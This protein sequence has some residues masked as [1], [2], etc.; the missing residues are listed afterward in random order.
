MEG[1]IDCV[2]SKYPEPLAWTELVQNEASHCLLVILHPPSFFVVVYHWKL[3]EFMM[4][5]RDQLPL[6]LS[7]CSRV[8]NSSHWS[9]Y[10]SLSVRYLQL[11]FFPVVGRKFRR[12]YLYLIKVSPWIIGHIWLIWMPKIFG[13][14]VKSW[15]FSLV[16]EVSPILFCIVHTIII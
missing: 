14:T 9:K 1:S 4:L 7:H 2:A 6:P 10:N 8:Y 15:Y 5:K 16:T 12:T 13:C 11:R 3:Q